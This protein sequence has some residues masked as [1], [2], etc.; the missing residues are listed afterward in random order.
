VARL[1]LGSESRTD[2][3]ARL[4]H[5][6]LCVTDLDRSVEF[7]Q[8]VAAMD[9]VERHERVSEQFD[10]LI[11][12]R[13]TAVRVAYLRRDAFLL[14]L[15]EYTRA[16]EPAASVAHSRPGS[17]HLSFI[18]SDVAAEYERLRSVP[19][20]RI[21]SPVV[22]LNPLMTSFY[23]SDPDGVPVELLELTGPL[24][25]YLRDSHGSLDD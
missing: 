7:Y 8:A 17:P 19:D 15:I 24:P 4:F 5:V 10:T 22:V 25:E 14:Q 13:G 6:G 2:A 9:V 21:T 12:S 16:G 23:T 1:D 11:G 20:V 3:R 18:V